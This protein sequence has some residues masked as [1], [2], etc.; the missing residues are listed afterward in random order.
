MRE[1]KR[2]SEDATNP[3]LQADVVDLFASILEGEVNDIEY[4]LE[5]GII[6][7]YLDLLPTANKDL[8]AK[9]A[10]GIEYYYEYPHNLDR[11]V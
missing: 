4:L 1:L 8:F 3:E 5:S 11:L 6:Q 7:N 9:L 10:K 2:I